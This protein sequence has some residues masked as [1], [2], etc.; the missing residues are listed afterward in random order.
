MILPGVEI[1]NNVIVAAGAEVTK[2]YKED[3][4]IIGGM[5]AKII[6]KFLILLMQII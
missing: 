5:P 4:I 2:S 1:G 3:N 6:K